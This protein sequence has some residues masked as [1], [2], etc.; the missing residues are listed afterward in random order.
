MGARGDFNVNFR[1]FYVRRAEQAFVGPI[2]RLLA[3]SARQAH[4]FLFILGV[5]RNG[6]YESRAASDTTA[7]V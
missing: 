4:A 5:E 6:A 1:T 2:G 3:Q 7:A